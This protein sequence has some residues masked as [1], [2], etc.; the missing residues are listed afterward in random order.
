MRRITRHSIIAFGTAAAL[1]SAADTSLAAKRR[2]WAFREIRV[3]VRNHLLPDVT[4]RSFRPARALDNGTLYFLVEGT[5]PG[6]SARAQLGTDPGAVTVG[7]LDAAFV[8]ALGLGPDAERA[9]QHLRDIGYHPRADFGTEIAARALGIRENH[10]AERDRL[11]RAA[12]ESATR[13][14]AAFTAARVFSSADVD[15]ARTILQ[16]V[17]AI[18]API[19]ERQAILDRAIQMVGQPYVW[20]GNWEVGASGAEGQKHGGFDCSG[21]VWRVAANDPAAAP[22]AAK[23]LGARSTYEMARRTPVAERLAREAVQPGDALYYGA[24]G[25]QADWHGIG[26]MGLDLGGGLMIHSSSYGVFISPWDSG[27]Y[28]TRFAFGKSLVA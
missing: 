4:V 16:R 8:R 14:Q 25:V 20:G 12:D 22:I 18:T 28:Q 1:L 6:G 3:V 15:Y 27:W 7:E 17:A 13:A 10:A 21:L 11:E 2:N 24:G 5:V 23:R 9:T 26:H 19:G